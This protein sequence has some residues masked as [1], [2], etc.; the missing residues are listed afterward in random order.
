M[1]SATMVQAVSLLSKA[2]HGDVLRVIGVV[3]DLALKRPWQCLSVTGLRPS[4]P[5]AADV[6]GASF[7]RLKGDVP[8]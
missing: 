8:S 5:Q 1:P 7:S 4:K 6:C 3:V 2:L